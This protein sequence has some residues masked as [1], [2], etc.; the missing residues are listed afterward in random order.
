M[1]QRLR[2]L[3]T[4]SGGIGRK[5]LV[6]HESGG[7]PE[8]F[9]AYHAAKLPAVGAATRG[10][11]KRVAALPLSVYE[12]RR[13][14]TE[15][16]VDATDPEAHLVTR[17]WS[18]HTTRQDGVMHLLRSVLL[19]G[20]G[21]A[22]VQRA[23][24]GGPAEALL[25]LD[26]AQVQREKVGARRVYRVS[27]DGVGQVEV[28]RDDLIFLTFFPPADGVSDVSPLSEHWD[29]IRAA[30]GAL[31]WTGHFFDRGAT[32][33]LLYSPDGD[34]RD[35]GKETRA[36][37]RLENEMRLRGH[38][39]MTLPKGYQ[40]VSIG[41]NAL[42]A[43]VQGSLTFGVQDV[44][45]IYE[46][47]PPFLGDLSRATY[48]NIQE[49]REELA[50][51]LEGWAGRLAAEIS[52]IMWPLGNRL[53]RFDT[54][55]LA[56]ERY[57]VRM[58]AYRDGRQAGVLT[59]NEARRMEQLPESEQEGADDLTLDAAPTMVEVEA[60]GVE[61]RIL[62]HVGENGTNGAG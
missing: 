44:A 34:V 43:N 46:V 29:A 58:K 61:N 42:D 26:P 62:E 20:R 17:R 2:R 7:L 45:R 1:I 9:S 36:L 11:A 37:W 60:R 35:V 57:S 21:A 56:L 40:P 19:D 53:V 41:T 48:S 25:P 59:P 38:R 31:V 52:N 50:E 24:P 54:S 14:G 13:D 28:E 3:F 49:A 5:W 15:E 55:R 16:L 12:V 30:L 18:A 39:S 6:G 23:S 32:P 47:P 33:K 27:F 22:L 4:R 10:I 51:T 8:H